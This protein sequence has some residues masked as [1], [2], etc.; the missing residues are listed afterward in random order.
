MNLKTYHFNENEE[1]NQKNFIN[2]KM[3]LEITQKLELSCDIYFKVMHKGGMKNKMI[4]R[5]AIN[6][7]FIEEKYSKLIITI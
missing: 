3:K 6:P 7:A 2:Q 4:C 5:F 1:F